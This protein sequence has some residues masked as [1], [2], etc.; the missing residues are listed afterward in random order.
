MQGNDDDDEVWLG[1]PTAHLN[2]VVAYHQLVREQMQ[3][4]L[5]DQNKTVSCHQNSD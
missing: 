3:A 5:R 4:M 2:H 1:E